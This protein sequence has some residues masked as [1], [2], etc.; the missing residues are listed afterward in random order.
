M[1]LYF[2]ERNMAAFR[3]GLAYVDG[4]SLHRI[5][6]TT[7]PIH[8]QYGGTKKVSQVNWREMSFHFQLFFQVGGH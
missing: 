8:T 7:L 3:L 2:E 6:K 5:L 1:F 4:P